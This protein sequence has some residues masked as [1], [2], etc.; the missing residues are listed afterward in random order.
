MQYSAR[1]SLV[2]MSLAGL[3]AGLFWRAS[4]ADE[5]IVDSTE[6]AAPQTL[7]TATVMHVK[8]TSTQ[9][10]LT[11]LLSED[12]ESIA[13]SARELVGLARDVPPMQTGDA[14]ADQAYEHFRFEMLRLSADLERMGKEQNLT[15]AAYIH[16]N[17]TSA[18][19]GCHQYMREQSRPIQLMGEDVTLP[20]ELEPSREAAKPINVGV[21]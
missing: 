18:C 16:G 20:T 19:I 5:P 13:E 17:L 10:V 12:Y 21:R 6:A 2:W 1:K 4:R 9:Q 11:G 14:S 3:L 8:L 7:P 15:G